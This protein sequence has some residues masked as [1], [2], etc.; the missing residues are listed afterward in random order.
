M[1][2]KDKKNNNFPI[3][4]ANWKMNGLLLE[5][6]QNFR[7]IRHNIINSQV[8]NVSCE[9]VV[10]PPFTLLRD[11]TEKVPGTGIRLGG[12]N[13]HH[14]PNG[15]FTGEISANMLA[16]M[17]C[18]YVILG[19]SERRTTMNEGSETVNKKATIAH[20]NKLTTIICVGETK[21]ERDNDLARIVVREQVIHSIPKCSTAENTVIAYEPVWAIGT[22]VTP[23]IAQIEEMHQ[24]IAHIISTELKQFAQVPRIVYGGSITSDNAKSILSADGVSGL[25]VGKACLDADEFW[26]IIELTK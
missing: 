22:G 20:A 18:D 5:S 15:A 1:T 25:L 14:E 21:Y 17:K 7:K 12:Q 2:K 16:D 11:F 24:Y 10:C 6:M 23:T 3:I 4:I 19:H 8:E 26:Q 9:V 13:C